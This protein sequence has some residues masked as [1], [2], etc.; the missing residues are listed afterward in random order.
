MKKIENGAEVE[1][2]LKIETENAVEEVALEIEE[3]GTTIK[4]VDENHHYI[5]MSHRQGL[6][7]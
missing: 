5:G 7:I 6:S 4:H 1:A 3:I 2:G